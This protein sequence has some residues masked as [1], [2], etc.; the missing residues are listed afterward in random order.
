MEYLL[1]AF[2]ALA[3]A[4]PALFQNVL[5]GDLGTFLDKMDP[6]VLPDD[7]YLLRPQTLTEGDVVEMGERFRLPASPT[8]ILSM[9]ALAFYVITDKVPGQKGTCGIRE[10]LEFLLLDGENAIQLERR[11][12]VPLGTLTRAVP[13]PSFLI[14]GGT[15]VQFQPKA[16][17]PIESLLV[18]GDVQRNFEGAVHPEYGAVTTEVSDALRCADLNL[19]FLSQGGLRRS[20]LALEQMWFYFRRIVH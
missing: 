8:I 13:Y 5:N 14:G 15:L 1:E 3:W 10:C 4:N 9:D 11:C 18:A 2:R 20:A 17:E 19:V 6:I 7:P 12:R 16:G